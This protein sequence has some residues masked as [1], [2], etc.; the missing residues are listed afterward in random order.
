MSEDYI[1]IN[2]FSNINHNNKINQNYGDIEEH[3]N[4][5]YEKGRPIFQIQSMKDSN[6]CTI[7]QIGIMEKCNDI[8]I[9]NI[10]LFDKYNCFIVSC[11]YD[12]ET[13]VE[14]NLNT[15]QFIKIII[16]NK[17]NH[18]EPIA[19]LCYNFH[20]SEDNLNHI[21][22]KINGYFSITLHFQESNQ[23][24]IINIKNYKKF[25]GHD[26]I[27]EKLLKKLLDHNVLNI[28][29]KLT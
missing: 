14:K 1:P 23:A 19:K 22:D 26:R 3:L 12:N 17:I 24:K 8:L 4:D 21:D 5:M 25:C 11:V 2:Q 29:N 6:S 10:E 20:K 7:K 15:L 28:I 9:K 27:I 18:H 16:C 13:I